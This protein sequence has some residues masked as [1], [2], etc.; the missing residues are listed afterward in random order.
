M[1]CAPFVALDEHKHHL[2]FDDPLGLVFSERAQSDQRRSLL[3]AFVLT[4]TSKAVDEQDPP[5]PGAEYGEP[6]FQVVPEHQM[7]SS[8]MR[9]QWPKLRCRRRHLT[10]VVRPRRE[11]FTLAPPASLC[12]L[13]VH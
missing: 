4:G 10:L 7:F 9:L 3:A 1:L 11:K 6:R 2:A 12:G 8:T 5:V 13:G